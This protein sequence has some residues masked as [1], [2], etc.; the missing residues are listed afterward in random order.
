M[1]AKGIRAMETDARN[2]VESDSDILT[3]EVPD[4][5]L[6]RAAAVTNGQAI[7][8]GICTDWYHCNWPQWLPRTPAK[9]HRPRAGMGILWGALAFLCRL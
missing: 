9:A 1:L 2:V 6:E 4:D 5:V 7:T 8:V 3:F